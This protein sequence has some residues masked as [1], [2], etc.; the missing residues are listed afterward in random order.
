MA[1]EDAVSQRV[2]DVYRMQPSGRFKH[3]GT[4]TEQLCALQSEACTRT[5]VVMPLLSFASHATPQRVCFACY[6]ELRNS[7]NSGSRKAKETEAPRR[8]GFSLK[9]R[10]EADQSLAQESLRELPS[11]PKPKDLLDY[12]D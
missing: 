1:T 5:S 9:R 8:T 10:K 2:F 12:F 6:M 11:D 4:E 3:V 7:S